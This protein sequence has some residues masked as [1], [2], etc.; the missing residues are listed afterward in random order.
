MK[1]LTSKNS[2]EKENFITYLLQYTK[3]SCLVYKGQGIDTPYIIPSIGIDYY[4]T[5]YNKLLI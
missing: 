5:L 4:Y 2:I 3:Y 1:K